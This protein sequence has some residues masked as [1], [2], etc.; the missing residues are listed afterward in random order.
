[1]ELFPPFWWPPSR[2]PPLKRTV[3]P[4]L[5]VLPG[6]PPRL[7]GPSDSQMPASPPDL[8]ISRFCKLD[9]SLFSGAPQG[10]LPAQI[11]ARIHWDLFSLK[12]SVRARSWNDR[13]DSPLVGSDEDLVS[14]FFFFFFFFFF[15]VFVILI[16]FTSR[17]IPLAC[18]LVLDFF[19]QGSVGSR[20]V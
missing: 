13:L 11:G 1:M 18:I 2:S 19:L 17:Y 7:A 10:Q 9:Y 20:T 8:L 12:G 14:F 16:C 4:K 6:L 5:W 3:L 15:C